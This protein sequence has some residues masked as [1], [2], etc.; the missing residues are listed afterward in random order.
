L[1][2]IVIFLTLIFL[3]AAVI[4][5]WIY[6]LA[7]GIC[8]ADSWL[9]GHPFHRYYGRTVQVLAVLGLWPF[10]RALGQR[11]L[12]DL[13]L[14]RPAG[15]WGRLAGG[16]ALGFASLA[17]VAWVGVAVGARMVRSEILGPKLVELLV[18]SAAGAGVVAMLE[19]VLFRGALFGGLRRAWPWPF[20]LAVSSAVYALVHFMGKGDGAQAVQW[21]S[22]FEMLG[23][24]LGGFTHWREIVPGFFNLALA[25]AILGL[26]YQRTGNLY[27]S[28][29]LH[30]GWIFWLKICKALTFPA[31]DRTWLWGTWKLVDGWLALPLLLVVLA[32]VWRWVGD[33]RRRVTPGFQDSTSGG[34]R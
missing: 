16:F 21:Y 32:V 33:G 19:E 15:Q 34:M 26:A 24:L 7:L 10:L 1:R 8:G 6:R 4:S 28:I 14:G 13:G 29:G 18:K 31:S 23:Q 9:G 17:V 22:G 2:A 20:A 30:A 12:A 11:S 27:Y 3:S 5:P 25:G